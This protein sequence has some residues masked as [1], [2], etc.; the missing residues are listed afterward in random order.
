M[1]S[2][3]TIETFVV[4]R[5]K[6]MYGEQPPNDPRTLALVRLSL[7]RLR[8]L[9]GAEAQRAGEAR[10]GRQGLREMPLDQGAGAP[11]GQPKTKG[12]A[13]PSAKLRRSNA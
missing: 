8:Q 13:S 5:L 1:A 10:H 3:E 6:V 4:K 7:L 12:Q 2:A 11:Q 9:G